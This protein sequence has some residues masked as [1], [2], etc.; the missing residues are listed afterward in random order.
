[1]QRYL[2]AF[3]VRA[4]ELNYVQRIEQK[5]NKPNEMP[6]TGKSNDVQCLFLQAHS[7]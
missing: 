7:A 4:P 6:G 2:H 1:M 5:M 3:A